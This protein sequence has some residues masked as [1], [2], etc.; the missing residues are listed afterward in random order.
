MSRK[1]PKSLLGPNLRTLQPKL[2]MIANGDVMVNILRAELSAAVKVTDARALA[3]IPRVRGQGSEPMTKQAFRQKFKR[4]LRRPSHLKSL[5]REV[6]VNVFI[7]TTSAT[8]LPPRLVRECG[9]RGRITKAS[10]PISKLPKLAADD[11]VRF[12]E[13]GEL[14]K[15]PQPIVSTKTVG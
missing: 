7:H 11:R 12:I 2:R 5:A 9:R 10:V 15:I 1:S 6:M 14:L 4:K 8:E 13:L 3:E